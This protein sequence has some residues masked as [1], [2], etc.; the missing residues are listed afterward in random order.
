MNEDPKKKGL[1]NDEYMDK[2]I[3]GKATVSNKQI[4]AFIKEK[5]IPEQSINPQIKERIKNYLLVEEKK[6]MVQSHGICMYLCVCNEIFHFLL[7]L[8]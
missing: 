6:K 3:A 1:S 5:K 8:I 2:Y 4:D 7:R